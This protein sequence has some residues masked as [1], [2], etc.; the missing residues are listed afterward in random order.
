MQLVIPPPPF[1]Y[2]V[3]IAIISPPQYMHAYEIVSEPIGFL[4]GTIAVPI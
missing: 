1:L 3:H 4:N 2:E